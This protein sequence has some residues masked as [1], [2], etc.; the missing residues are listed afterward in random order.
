MATITASYEYADGDIVTVS[1]DM[2][3]PYPDALNEAKVNCVAM[4]REVMSLGITT[5]A[6]DEDD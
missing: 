1:I 6:D 3:T 2:P 4:L 5:Q